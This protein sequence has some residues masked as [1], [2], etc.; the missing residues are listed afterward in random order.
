MEISTSKQRKFVWWPIIG[1]AALALVLAASQA[2]VDFVP[3][4]DRQFG[5][6]RNIVGEFEL[7]I[8]FIGAPL[9]ALIFVGTALVL[10]L[11]GRWRTLLSWL[12]APVIFLSALVVLVCLSTF[13][14]LDPYYWFVLTQQDRLLAAANASARP[15]IM[16]VD[17]RDVSSG[18]AGLNPSSVVVIVYD[19]SDSLADPAN[20]PRW[21]AQNN[22]ILHGGLE[23]ESIGGVHRIH[24]HFYIVRGSYG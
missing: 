11:V 21:L 23:P 3:I 17:V 7:G 24:G 13:W 10:P 2:F 8:F 19:P 9:G 4:G 14:L 20:D 12:L 6:I 15:G 18:I 22:G 5:G 1:A 16:I